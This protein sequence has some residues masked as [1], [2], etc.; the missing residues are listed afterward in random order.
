MDDALMREEGSS[1]PTCPARARFSNAHSFHS[2]RDTKSLPC[3]ESR[4]TLSAPLDCSL[5]VSVRCCTSRER[6]ILALRVC[7]SCKLQLCRCVS[8][9]G[10]YQPSV[11]NALRLTII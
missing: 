5:V 4:A 10:L 9:G 11:T 3:S 7:C 8:V 6:T 1:W 2:Q